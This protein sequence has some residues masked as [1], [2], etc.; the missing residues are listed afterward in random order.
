MQEFFQGIKFIHKYSVIYQFENAP[1]TSPVTCSYG[2]RIFEIYKF[3]IFTWV[4]NTQKFITSVKIDEFEKS[5]RNIA[6]EG[7]YFIFAFGV[8]CYHFT[9][10]PYG[11][12]VYH[13]YG[14]RMVCYKNGY[15]S[16]RNWL[17]S[18]IRAHFYQIQQVVSLYHHSNWV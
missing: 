13:P 3:S 12:M 16:T 8:L 14:T 17:E 15:H 4:Q 9:M 11:S 2:H 5:F 18:N 1:S 6:V 7:Q 10:L